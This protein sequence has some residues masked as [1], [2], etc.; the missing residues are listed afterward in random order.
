LLDGS[1]THPKSVPANNSSSAPAPRTTATTGD[2][3]IPLY[4]FDSASGVQ[5]QKERQR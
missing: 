3:E 2:F 4:M 1:A 5:R